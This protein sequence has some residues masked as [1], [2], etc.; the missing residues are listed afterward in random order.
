[1]IAPIASGSNAPR[2]PAELP[3][4]NGVSSNI[5]M[6]YLPF[7]FLLYTRLVLVFRGCFCFLAFFFDGL[8]GT[9]GSS[10]GFS[11]AGVNGVPSW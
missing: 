1:M 4:K 6:S 7:L 5:F 2:A 8:L 11:N 10:N 9:S 3:S